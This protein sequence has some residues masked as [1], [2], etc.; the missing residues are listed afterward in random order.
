MRKLIV[1]NLVSLDG[2]FE[3]PGADVMALPFD[4]A[5]DNYNAERLRHADAVLMGRKFFEQAKDYWPGVAADENARSA[6]REVSRALNAVE[7]VVVSDSLTAGR[8]APS[9]YPDREAGGRAP[10]RR[11]H[12]AQDRQGHARVR[13]SH[14]LE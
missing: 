11:R 8:T 9:R 7:K 5:F 14:A 4:P 1:V 12:E 2:Y 3:G 10:I 13:Q 6:E